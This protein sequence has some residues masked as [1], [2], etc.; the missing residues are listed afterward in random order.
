MPCIKNLET[1]NPDLTSDVMSKVDEAIDHYKGKPGSL[2]P[3]L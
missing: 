3:V 1:L 2:I